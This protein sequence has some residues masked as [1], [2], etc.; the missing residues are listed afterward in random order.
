MVVRQL[1]DAEYI[2]RERKRARRHVTRLGGQE[3]ASL[4]ITRH[5]GMSSGQE[6]PLVIDCFV[7]G[8]ESDCHLAVPSPTV[9]KRHAELRF[10]DGQWSIEDLRTRNG[11][12]VNGQR[13]YS[14]TP[15]SHNDEIRI[16]AFAPPACTAVFENA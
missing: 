13:I 8:R 3:M 16:P 14:R 4:R 2:G 1:G 12:C 9:S 11:T 6:I 10:Q 15:L 7:I 5:P